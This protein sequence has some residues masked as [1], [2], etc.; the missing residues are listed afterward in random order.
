MADPAAATTDSAI[1]ALRD[2]LKALIDRVC[3]LTNRRCRRGA[4][5]RCTPTRGRGGRKHHTGS[6]PLH[7]PCSAAAD[8]GLVAGIVSVQDN[9][10]ARDTR[11]TN[12]PQ[13]VDCTTPGGVLLPA[14][15]APAP[16]RPSAPS[17]KASVFVAECSRLR[18][19]DSGP[20]FDAALEQCVAAETVKPPA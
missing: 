3:G 15:A 19:G 1:A 17:L 2:A 12:D 5:R 4:R 18:P 13:V 20:V 7:W 10:I 9:R 16:G 11:A 6:W 8:A 14:R